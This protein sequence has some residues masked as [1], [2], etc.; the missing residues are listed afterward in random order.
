MNAMGNVNTSITADYPLAA[1]F[2]Q[3]GEVTYVAQNYSNNPIT[4]TFSD[5]FELN[6]PA[7][8]MATNRDLNVTGSISTDYYQAYANGSIYLY[9]EVTGTGVTQVEFYDGNNPIGNVT[10]APY[11]IKADSL[12]LGIH[13]YY[14]KIYVGDDYTLTNIISVQVGEQSP[15]LDTLTIPGI[16]EAGYYD[17]YNGG[18]GQGI[19]YVDVSQNNEG[20][21]RPNEYVDAAIDNQEGATVGWIASGEW[22][23][24]TV[25]VESAALYDLSFRY[26][27]GNEAGGGPFILILDEDTIST[28]ISVGYTGDWGAWATQ[29]VSNLEIPSGT[30]ILKIAFLNG[31]FNLG[32]MTFSYAG[33][34]GYEPPIADAGETQIVL[35]PETTANLNGSGSYDPD[36]ATLTYFWEQIYGSSVATIS[37]ATLENPQITNLE[38]GYYKFKLTVNDGSHNAFDEVLV[39]VTSN[40]NLAPSVSIISPSNNSTFHEGTP[41]N[42]KAIA[43]DLDGTIALVEFFDGA[44]KIGEITTEPY[45]IFWVDATIGSHDIK[46]KATDNDGG[47]SISAA[48]NI[49]IEPTPSCTGEPANG[50]YSY[51]F[52]PDLNNPTLTFIPSTSGY[53]TPTCI[54]YYGTTTSGPFPGYNVTPNTPFQI[55]EEEGTVIYFYYTYSTP[56]G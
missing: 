27:S 37:E 32:K 41:I 20:G 25:N 6:V 11:K 34:L 24:Y 26:A 56:T 44:T 19:T 4:V 52:S 36:G 18:V 30:H 50:E 45:E 28:E 13:S 16:I 12:T 51:E 39:I 42:L 33:E 55:M 43:S 5:G 29:T 23:E 2:T 15:Y 38:E 8:Q 10:G 1:S 54:L 35:I 21:F 7:N 9:T 40:E 47:T 31:E 48:V 46:A 53:G 17:K 49:T 22:L 14:A 3:N